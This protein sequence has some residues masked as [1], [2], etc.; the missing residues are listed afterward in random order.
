VRR[1]KGGRHL[2]AGERRTLRCNCQRREKGAH[3]REDPANILKG[4]N[5]CIDL[6][7]RMFFS[8]GGHSAAC[9]FKGR[10]REGGGIW[11]F[12]SLIG[13]D[14]KGKKLGRVDPRE[15]RTIH[16]RRQGGGRRKFLSMKS[17]WMEGRVRH[18]P[19]KRG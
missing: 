18:E 16:S 7:E 14:R 17:R 5:I 13:L 19:K 12:F 4:G 8:G 2:F 9:P 15:S 10:G 3:Q 11:T 1:E 6:R